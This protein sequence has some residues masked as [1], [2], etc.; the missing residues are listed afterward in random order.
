MPR[1]EEF[2]A[3]NRA[4]LSAGSAS[5]LATLWKVD[6]SASVS[7]MKQFYARLRSPGN[8]HDAAS[9]LAIAQRH[10][11]RSREL[12]HPYYWASYVVVGQITTDVEVVEGPSRR[13]L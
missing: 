4:F 5:V 12:G 6:D 3:M 13:S 9:A 1:G 10:H 7:L 8:E 2:V 11:R